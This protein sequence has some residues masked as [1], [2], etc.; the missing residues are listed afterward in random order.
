MSIDKLGGGGQLTRAGVIP[1]LEGGQRTHDITVGLR[2]RSVRYK[3]AVT[4]MH[5]SVVWD[6]ETDG[7]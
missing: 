2:E 1:I 3:P 4:V 7:K 5:D 6:F